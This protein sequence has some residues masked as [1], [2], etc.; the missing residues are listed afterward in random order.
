MEELYSRESIEKGYH[1]LTD[2]Q[3]IIVQEFLAEEEPERWY[4]LLD[5]MMNNMDSYEAD[6]DYW[7][8]LKSSL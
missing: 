7:N 4:K 3:W 2:K 6:Y 8:N 5:D 1:K